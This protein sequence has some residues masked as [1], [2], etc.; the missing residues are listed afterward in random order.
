[1]NKKIELYTLRRAKS[2]GTIHFVLSL[3]LEQSISFSVDPKKPYI[4]YAT[5][6]LYGLEKIFTNKNN[7]PK[8]FLHVL[9]R[10]FFSILYNKNVEFKSQR[11]P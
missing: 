5:R 3:K 2:N 10:T 7:F 8:G 6:F 4:F 11:S 1:M 9:F